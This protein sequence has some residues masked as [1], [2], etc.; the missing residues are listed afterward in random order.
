MLAVFHLLHRHSPTALS[1]RGIISK[2]F[3]KWEGFFFLSCSGIYK[4]I[5]ISIYLSS[6]DNKRINF[7]KLESTDHSLNSCPNFPHSSPKITV[8]FSCGNYAF[9]GS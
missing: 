4:C 2:S 8:P 6:L 1:P 3:K 7:K 5:Y 9:L